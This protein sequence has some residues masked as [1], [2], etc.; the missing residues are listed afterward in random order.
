MLRHYALPARGFAST[1]GGMLQC[2]VACRFL[3]SLA[4]SKG[5][6]PT[7]SEASQLLK[8]TFQTK[9][10]LDMDQNMECVVHKGASDLDIG[11][12]YARQHC[13]LHVRPDE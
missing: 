1:D 8:C 6:A 10:G 13:L 9:A 2:D 3:T 5:R 11:A 7:D 4:N 12:C